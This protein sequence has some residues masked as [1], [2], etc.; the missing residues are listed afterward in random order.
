M[1]V[2]HIQITHRQE[3]VPLTRNYIEAEEKRLK[4]LDSAPKGANSETRSVKKSI[5][6]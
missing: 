6:A 3:A 5:N 2:F 1:M 4:R